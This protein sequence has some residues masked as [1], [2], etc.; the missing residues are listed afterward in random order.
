MRSDYND[1]WRNMKVYDCPTLSPTCCGSGGEAG[2]LEEAGLSPG[3][4]GV[5]RQQDPVGSSWG[6]Y[7]HPTNQQL[8]LSVI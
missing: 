5:I 3:A 8:L 7:Y 6:R 4:M 2:P 1:V